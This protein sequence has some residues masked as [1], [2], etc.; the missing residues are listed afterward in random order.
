MSECRS[1]RAVLDVC[2]QQTL[3]SD[4]LRMLSTH[5]SLKL[6]LKRKHKLKP[7]KPWLVNDIMLKR[8]DV[9]CHA[10]CHDKRISRFHTFHGGGPCMPIANTLLYGS[11]KY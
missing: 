4:L 3:Q 6:K 5:C 10:Q 7:E 11:I 9:V 8:H 2:L 1:S